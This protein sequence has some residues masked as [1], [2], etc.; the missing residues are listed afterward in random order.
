MKYIV[1]IDEAY[2]SITIIYV[3]IFSQIVTRLIIKSALENF[4]SS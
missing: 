4:D 1:V 3:T 2:M